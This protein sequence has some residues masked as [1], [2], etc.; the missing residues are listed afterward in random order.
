MRYLTMYYYAVL[1]MG[2][3]EMGPVNRIEL[4]Y[5]VCTL[6]AAALLNALIFGDIASLTMV[7]SRK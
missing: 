4:M 5:M 1:I 6:M 2:S 7:F 3:N